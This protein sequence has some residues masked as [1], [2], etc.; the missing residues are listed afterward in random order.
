MVK[1]CGNCNG[2]KK[3]L[4]LDDFIEKKFI[5]EGKKNIASR[6]IPYNKNWIGFLHNPPKGNIPDCI[7]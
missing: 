2:K 7:Y 1:I 6:K 4:Y 5:W 3:I